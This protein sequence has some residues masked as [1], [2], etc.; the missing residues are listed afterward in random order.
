MVGV[1]QSSGQSENNSVINPPRVDHLFLDDDRNVRP[2]PHD[3]LV[4]G[5]MRQHDCSH[6]EAER[7]LADKGRHQVERELQEKGRNSTRWG[8]TQ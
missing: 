3:D 5:L 7:I 1:S 4:T 2:R 6:P 8:G